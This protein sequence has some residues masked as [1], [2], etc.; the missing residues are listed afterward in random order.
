VI[1][2]RPLPRFSV[3]PSDLSPA[4]PPSHHRAGGGFQNPWLGAELGFRDFLRWRFDRLRTTLPADP[5]R[6]S[7]PRVAPSFA[8]PRTAPDRCSVT[9]VGHSTVLVQAGALNILTDPIWSTFAG[10]L[11]GFGPRRWVP[12][13]IAFGELPPIDLVLLSHNHYDHLDDRTVRRLIA[14]HPDAQWVAPLGVAGFVRHRGARLVTELDWWQEA[15][16]GSARVTC[17]PAQHFSARG[18]FDRWETLWASFAVHA[19]PHAVY[20]GGDSGYHPDFTAIGA[21]YGPF[22]VAMLPI[23]AYEPRWFMRAMHMDPDEAVRAFHD[24]N[25][26]AA[27]GRRGAMVAMHWGTFKLTDEALDEPPVRARA[28]WA[29][30]GAHPD[31]L[32]ILPHGG[33]RWR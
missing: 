19:G 29:R 3:S 31:D 15:E 5:E 22:D 9:W 32:W 13:G 8:A 26:R 10:P 2:F 28:A 7:L 20:F 23:G 30:A 25:A 4:A 33:T 14:A 12:P 1:F 18:P 24:L 11:P 27:P 6:T 17:L 21:R 16:L